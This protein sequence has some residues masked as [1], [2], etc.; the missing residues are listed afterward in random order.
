[1]GS[2]SWSAPRPPPA[3]LDALGEELRAAQR[4]LDS[5]A[6]QE[7]SLRRRQLIDALA[8]QAFTVSGQHPPSPALRD[9]VT[10]MLADPQVAEQLRAGALERAVHRDGLGPAAPPALAP[11]PWSRAGHGRGPRRARLLSRRGPRRR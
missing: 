10:A 1:V 7:L 4:S 9:E 11:L 2:T 5:V 6:I 3:Q 8:R